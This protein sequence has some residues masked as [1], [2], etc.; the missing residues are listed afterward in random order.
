[1]FPVVIQFI[2]SSVCFERLP[3]YRSATLVARFCADAVAPAPPPK[4]ACVICGM[5]SMLMMKATNTIVTGIMFAIHMSDGVI[6]VERLL[7]EM[8]CRSRTR[9]R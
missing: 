2:I 3:A 7:E 9:R 4:I 5:K 6:T 1:M 8:S